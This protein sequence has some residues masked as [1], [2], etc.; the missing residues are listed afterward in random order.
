MLGYFLVGLGLFLLT[1]ANM[2]MYNITPPIPDYSY[3]MPGGPR[4]NHSG[5]QRNRLF[6]NTSQP[7]V[8]K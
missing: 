1:R 4:P 3:H 8:K 5:F 2:K 6:S 7:D